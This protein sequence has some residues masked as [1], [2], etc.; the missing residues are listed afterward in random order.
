MLSMIKKILIVITCLLVYSC[1]DAKDSAFT[2][3][4]ELPVEVGIESIEN[5]DNGG[6]I[7]NVYIENHLLIG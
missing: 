2:L 5:N 4:P 7:I 3:N 6:V 1:N